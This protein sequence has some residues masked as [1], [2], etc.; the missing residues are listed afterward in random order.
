MNRKPMYMT[1]WI[2]KLDDFL[3][4]SD[5]EVLNH[6]GKISHDSAKEKAEAEYKLY[7]EQQAAL[8][9]PVDEDFEKTLE[10]L[11]KVEEVAKKETTMK[12]RKKKKEE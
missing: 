4:L 8:P 9:Q 10:E 12:K 1:D 5:R 2:K 11:K 3:H 6:A 7:K